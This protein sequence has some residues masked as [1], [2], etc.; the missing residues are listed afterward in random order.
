MKN[1][2]F[3]NRMKLYEGHMTRKF[4]KPI[5]FG[6]P[7]AKMHI[8]DLH[9]ILDQAIVLAGGLQQPPCA[10]EQPGVWKEGRA[11][12][13][14]EFEDYIR[15]IAVALD[16]GHL[17]FPSEVVEDPNIKNPKPFI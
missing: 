17:L 3:S 5:F 15:D 13:K 4:T 9:D 10:T 14:A 1:D 2:E 11:E 6:N 16:C 8:H 12:E 7:L